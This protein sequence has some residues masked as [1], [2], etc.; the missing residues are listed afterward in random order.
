MPVNGD[1]G[2]TKPRRSQ[3]ER[4]ET[5]RAALLSAG[6]ALFATSGFA[7]TGREEIVERAGVTRGA[8][9]HH[10][11]GKEDLFLAVFEQVE[12]EL[13]ELV[14]TAAM[15]GKDPL[16]QL[17]LGCG[18]FLDACLDPA[19]QR[20]ALVDAPAVLGWATWHGI[21]ERYALGLVVEGVRHAMDAGQMAA[22]NPEPVAR[23][24]LGALTEAA[25][26]VAGAGKQQR[27]ARR[28]VGE[29]VDRLLAGLA[30]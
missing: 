27:V 2:H 29:I 10:F 19:V 22:G 4:S 1:K 3:A 6:R 16:A 14:A 12:T 8:L 24:L 23:V 13:M 5:T 11:T 7:G 9:Y 20:I 18:A 25:R 30:L 21:E 15:A 26:V 17:R 28:E